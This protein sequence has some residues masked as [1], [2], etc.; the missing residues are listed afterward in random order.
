MGRL[1]SPHS[2][3]H[4]S[5]SLSPS[6]DI[7]RLLLLLMSTSWFPRLL[8]GF[9][10]SSW[11][12]SLELQAALCF[13]CTQ[14]SSSPTASTPAPR[15]WLLSILPSTCPWYHEHSTGVARSG[16]SLSGTKKVRARWSTAQSLMEHCSEPD[17]A[18]IRT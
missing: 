17:G 9:P 3:R 10:A 5:S 16:G 15:P 18:L 8:S 1:S 4:P 2:C 11:C 13:S 6:I 12:L 14:P 7:F